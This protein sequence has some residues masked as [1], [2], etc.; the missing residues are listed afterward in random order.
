MLCRQ[1]RG[2]AARLALRLMLSKAPEAPV[3]IAL[4][5]HLPKTP[6]QFKNPPRQPKKHTPLR[7][8]E[9]ESPDYKMSGWKQ[10]LGQTII[11]VF[12]IDMDRLR[13]GPVA[14]SW[15]FGECKKQGLVYPN[16]PMSDTAKFYYQ[17]LGLPQLFSQ[18]FLI[19]ALHY[20]ILS[21]RMRAMPA[22]YGKN[23]QQKLVDRIF[24][25][26]EL[27]MAEELKISSNRIIENYLK[28]YHAQLLGLVLSYD[29]GLATDDITLA[30]ALWRNVFNGDPNIDMRHL[31]ALVGYVRAQLYVLSKMSDREFGFGKFSFVPPNEVVV[32]LTSA[33]ELELRAKA[34]EE[35]AKMTLPSQKLVLSLDE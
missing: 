20:W 2:P 25:D 28:E 9:L 27:R 32:P 13:A 23:Y 24:K 7:P 17:T 15:Y 3:E 33:Q 18:W 16:E 19:T 4:E 5:S 35:F 29:E 12:G 30:Q 26:M 31:E 11:K 22:K 34:K 6:Q 8:H 21:V 14:G 1:I 10:Q